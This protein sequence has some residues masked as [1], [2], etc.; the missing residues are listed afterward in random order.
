[1]VNPPGKRIYV[2]LADANP[3][4]LSAMS[5]VFDRDPRFS[6][7]ATAAT[8]EGFLATVMRIP[9][10][11]AVID[12]TIP[13]LGAARLIEVLRSA[14]TIEAYVK[15]R[16]ASVRFTGKAYVL[17][18]TPDASIPVVTVNLSKIDIA[19]YRIGERNLIPM[20]REGTPRFGRLFLGLRGPKITAMGTQFAGD[21]ISV[22]SEVTTFKTGDREAIALRLLVHVDDLQVIDVLNQA[23]RRLEA[24]RRAV[25]RVLELGVGVG[26]APQDLEE[27]LVADPVALGRDARADARDL[28]GGLA[29]A[30]D[31]LGHPL[32]ERAVEL[33]VVR[34]PV[35]PVRV[36]LHE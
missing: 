29:G 27:D 24:H 28:L 22:G 34:G 21:I 8:A 32:S 23:V 3:L 2:V 15:D 4:V 25:R 13:S 36:V 6:L 12:W 5:A 9:V 26:P 19:I 31:D 11:V 17:P 16:S 1:M 14:A 7:I 18:K 35:M 10:D 30:E 33:F 20:I